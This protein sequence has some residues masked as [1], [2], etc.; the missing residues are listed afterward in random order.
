MRCPNG[1]CGTSSRSSPRSISRRFSPAV[2]RPKGFIAPPPIWTL[3]DKFGA[4]VDLTG[5]VPMN[6]DQ[7]SV[8]R[9]SALRDTLTAV[10][11]VLIILWLALRS[12]KIIGAVF[13]SLMVGL[14]ATAA[15]GLAMVGS[16]NLISIAFFVLFVGLGVDFGIQF[17]VRYRSERHDHGDLREAL[18]VGRPQGRRSARSGRSGHRRRIFRVSA[19]QLSRPF[20][21]RADCRLRHADR[22]RLQH[23]AGAGDAGA[24]QSAGRDPSRSASRA[25]RRW[26]IF[27]S[28]IASRSSPAPSC[29]SLPARRCCCICRSTSIRSICRT[30]PRHRS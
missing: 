9:D 16:F 8:I 6:D 2:R 13:F 3:H 11:G 5:Q 23:H 19:D 7:F 29:S 17:S 15:L 1:S 25:S 28:G 20:G 18:R 12:W 30:R 21:T 10:F 4:T 24:A 22:V 14:A 27:C 26:T